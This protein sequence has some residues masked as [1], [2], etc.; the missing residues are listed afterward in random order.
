M[1]GE[2]SNVSIG[3]GTRKKSLREEKITAKIDFLF[4]HFYVAIT[5]A[6]IVSPKASPYYL[7][8]P[9]AWGTW[10]KSYD[11]KYTNLTIAAPIMVSPISFNENLPYN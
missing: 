2:T 5:T 11:Q 8:W 6:D 3:N 1:Y 9:R 10:T 4:V 7:I